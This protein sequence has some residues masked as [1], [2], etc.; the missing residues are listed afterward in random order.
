MISCSI[1]TESLT[2]STRD[3]VGNSCGHIY[4]Y[5]CLLEW[6]RTVRTCPQCRSECDSLTIHKIYFN[7]EPSAPPAL[8]QKVA[9]SLLEKK[10]DEVKNHFE[11]I[12]TNFHTVNQNTKPT[13][14]G[15]AKCRKYW[16]LLFIA[17]GFA[18][19]LF[20]MAFLHYSFNGAVG[21]SGYEKYAH[22]AVDAI[23][24]LDNK[25]NMFSAKVDNE[26]LVLVK[27]MEENTRLLQKIEMKISSSAARNTS[28]LTVIFAVVIYLL[29]D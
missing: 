27:K 6:I 10:F 26:A 1:C 23:D 20:Y 2:D 16:L 12:L 25:L 9:L 22:E 13:I 19:L 15:I 17:L 29:L 14:T 24:H 5:N 3:V 21:Q 8:D 18:V 11:D 4:H 28:V 7:H